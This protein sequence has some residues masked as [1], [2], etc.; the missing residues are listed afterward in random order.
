[1]G[2]LFYSLVLWGFN[3][4]FPCIDRFLKIYNERFLEMFDWLENIKKVWIFN[5][6]IRTHYLKIIAKNIWMNLNS[7]NIMGGYPSYLY[8]QNYPFAHQPRWSYNLQRP[9]ITC[10]HLF[11]T[12]KIW[13][14]PKN[15]S[16]PW[17]SLSRKRETFNRLARSVMVQRRH[18]HHPPPINHWNSQLT[19][20][21]TKP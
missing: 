6:L 16:K 21:P 1:M 14:F 20:S 11:S 12:S 19:F 5:R 4:L 10:I 13:E 9:I 17:T 8:N 18:N 15:A 3:I 2:W 7:A